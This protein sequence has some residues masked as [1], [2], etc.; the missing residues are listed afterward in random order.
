MGKTRTLH[1]WFHAAESVQLFVLCTRIQ[2]AFAAS[3]LFQ[4][5]LYFQCVSIHRDGNASIIHLKSLVLALQRIESSSSI[6]VQKCQ[7]APELLEN[8]C[9]LGNLVEGKLKCHN[10]LC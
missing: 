5:V 3:K 1:K 10:L 8:F 6:L 9:N 4:F 7:I 2:F